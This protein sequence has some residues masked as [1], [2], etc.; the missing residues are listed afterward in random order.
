MRHGQCT[1]V[2][3]LALGWLA[4]CGNGAHQISGSGT[5][6]PAGPAAVAIAR[7]AMDLG[8]N[9][10]GT[11]PLTILPG[12]QVTW[13][14]QD[15]IPHTATADDGLWDSGLLQPGESFSFTFTG[16]GTFA[17]HCNIHGAAMMSGTIIVSGPAGSIPA[18]APLTPTFKVVRDK[19]L[20]PH[21]MACHVPP[22][23]S[24]GLDF[25]TWDSLVHNPVLPD[26]IVPGSPDQSRLFIHI[27][28]AAG[29][30]GQE[31]MTAEEQQAVFDWIEAGAPDD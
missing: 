3:I 16:G 17:Y 15:D 7:G 5:A 29:G 4:S 19:I 22:S 23:P 24:G 31:A 25:T 12:T 8:S 18:P 30:G 26:L 2:S 11:N 13:T 28:A 9:A 6:Q 1:A 27:A 20:N 10:F 14:N 21:C